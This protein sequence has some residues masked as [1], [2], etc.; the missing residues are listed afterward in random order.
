MEL[1]AVAKRPS[2]R[3]E[4]RLPGRCASYGRSHD[5]YGRP[6][7]KLL[8]NLGDDLDHP[9]AVTSDGSD[10]GPWSAAED[11]VFGRRQEET[12]EDS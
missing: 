3:N 9:P 8:C 4:L 6:T 12:A 1:H 10:A 2:A 11:G 7:T 5:D